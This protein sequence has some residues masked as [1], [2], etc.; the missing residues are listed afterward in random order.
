MDDVWEVD[1]TLE[2][3]DFSGYA[4]D[5]APLDLAIRQDSDAGRPPAAGDGQQAEAFTAIAGRVADWLDAV[6]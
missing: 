6:R 3:I 1:G 4:E 2:P 5:R